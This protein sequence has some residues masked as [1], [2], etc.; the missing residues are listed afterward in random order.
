VLFSRVLFSCEIYKFVI[1]VIVIFD[2]S[3]IDV[4][5]W[6]CVILSPSLGLGLGSQ[7][8]VDIIAYHWLF[9]LLLQLLTS[10]TLTRHRSMNN[11]TVRLSPLTNH[12]MRYGYL[13]Q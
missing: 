6:S 3:N 12:A 7:V 1:I 9:L 10:L 8:L 4:A 11:D 2:P 13:L 5:C